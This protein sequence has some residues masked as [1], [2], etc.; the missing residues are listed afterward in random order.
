MNPSE[1]ESFVMATQEK[2]LRLA[3][4]YL[5]DWE[6]ARD[7]CQ[8]AFVKA[9]SGLSGRKK[10]SSAS[11]WFYR[12]LANHLKDR[13]RRRKFKRFFS[14]FAGDEGEVK[15]EPPDPSANPEREA[16]DRDIG[17]KLKSAVM[18]LPKRQGEVF[19]MKAVLGLT[20]SEISIALGI[21]EGAAKTH[22]Q[23]AL[24]ALRTSLAHLKDPP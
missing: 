13:L 14:L 22:H 6:E 8:E 4:S 24:E 5:G 10:E 15:A 9:H 18:A 7:A 12:I 17:E 2:A 11:T 20:F 23:R 1:F 3:Y 21:S 16:I 19:R